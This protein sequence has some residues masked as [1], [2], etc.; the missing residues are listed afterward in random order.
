MEPRASEVGRKILEIA[1]LQISHGTFDSLTESKALWKL[2]KDAPAVVGD[3]L[4]EVIAEHDMLDG[5]EDDASYAAVVRHVVV[6]GLEDA[7]LENKN[8]RTILVAAAGFLSDVAEYAEADADPQLSYY[9]L[10]AL[11]HVS[12][13]PLPEAGQTST[14]VY[15]YS[16]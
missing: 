8:I 12:G 16:N 15:D 11:C 10:A 1:H 3:L 7:V 13:A 6:A 14:V 9:Y 2:L 4:E 5:L